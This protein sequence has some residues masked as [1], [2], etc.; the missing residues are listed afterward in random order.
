M[1]IFCGCKIIDCN[2]R[3]K[4]SVMERN[5]SRYKHFR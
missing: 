5:E 2:E 1:I 3:Q 4:A